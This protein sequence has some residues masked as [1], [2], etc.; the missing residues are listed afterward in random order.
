MHIVGREKHSYIRGK[1]E[2]PTKSDDGFEKL[3]AENLKV[4]RWLLMSRNPEIMKR[5]LR[6]PTARQIWS[7]LAKA[8]HDGSDE[9]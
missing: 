1:I 4:N 5:Y 2:P 3:Y 7:A 6:L 9:L 8:F